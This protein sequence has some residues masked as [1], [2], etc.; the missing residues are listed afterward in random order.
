MW[1]IRSVNWGGKTPQFPVW[2]LPIGAAIL[3]TLVIIGAHM[4]GGG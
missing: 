4:N 3:I 2:F 1:W